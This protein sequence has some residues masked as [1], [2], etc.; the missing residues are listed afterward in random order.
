MLKLVRTALIVILGV[1]SA[2]CQPIAPQPS[3]IPENAVQDIRVVSATEPVKTTIKVEQFPLPN[4]GGSD[5]LTQGLRTYASATQSA[6]VG[7]KASIKGGGEAAIPETVK[8]KLE[9]QV[10]ASYQKTFESANSRLDSIE[11]SAAAGTHVIYTVVWEEQTFAS[12][13]RYS[14]NEQVYEAP[15]TYK[16]IVPKIDKS[17]N[18]ACTDGNAESRPAPAAPQVAAPTPRTPTESAVSTPQPAP[19]PTT[20]SLPASTPPRVMAKGE[21][22]YQDTFDDSS[23]WIVEEGVRIEN[24]TM[25]ISPRYDAVPQNP[26]T[27]AD[28]AFEFAVLYSC[29]GQ[30]G[31]LR[32]TPASGL[33]RLEL[34][35]SDSFVLR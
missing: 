11:M 15:Y 24:G 8:L 30:Y 17:Y 18:V 21:L 27:Y 2:S 4:C 31:F 26:V 14:S 12:I 6:T 1:I 29:N 16:L 22:L 23:G 20:P 32:A 3:S 33:S 7:A 34:Q 35:H 28:F 5:K 10:E 25:I 19:K 9:I 13:V